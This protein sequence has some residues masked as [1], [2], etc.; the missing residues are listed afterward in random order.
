MLD[1]PPFTTFDSSGLV[2]HLGASN[3]EPDFVA[4]CY[5]G[6]SNLLQ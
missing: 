2:V 1:P 4:H 6:S 3:I 5:Q